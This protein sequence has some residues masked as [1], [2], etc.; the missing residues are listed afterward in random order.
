MGGFEPEGGPSSKLARAL[1]K[2]VVGPLL[3]TAARRFRD[4]EGLLL[5]RDRSPLQLWSNQRTVQSA[6]AWAAWPWPKEARYDRI[7][8]QQSRRNA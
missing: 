6:F 3:A 8:L 7:S 4:R 5:R 2:A 1:G